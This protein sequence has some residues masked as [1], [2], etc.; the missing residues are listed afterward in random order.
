[1]VEGTRFVVL[2][3]GQ[4]YRFIA[5]VSGTPQTGTFRVAVSFRSTINDEEPAT[6]GTSYSPTFT[7]R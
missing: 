6:T 3:P 4:S 5:P 2:R 1:M 7:I